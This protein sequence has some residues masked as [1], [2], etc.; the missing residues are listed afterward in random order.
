M[1]EPPLVT[2]ECGPRPAGPP[3]ECFY[4]RR[5]LGQPHAADCVLWTKRVKVRAII[6]YE[7]DVPHAWDR[8]LIL[9]HLN[10]S[11]W[12]KT[13]ILNELQAILDAREL[14]SG[15]DECLDDLIEF[16]VPDVWTA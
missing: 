15:M 12:C 11:S 8:D 6:E 10:E 2:P 14:E 5:T 13:N 7:R 3:D 1:T 4:C 9:F 16:E